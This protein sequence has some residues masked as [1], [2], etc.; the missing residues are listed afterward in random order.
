MC[1]K[2][3]VH[4]EF[5]SIRGFKHPRGVLKQTPPVDNGRLLYFL[6][7][8]HEKRKLFVIWFSLDFHA[9]FTS[10][11]LTHILVASAGQRQ[12]V[13]VALESTQFLSFLSSPWN[14]SFQDLA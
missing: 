6:K 9:L 4:T 12:A 1:K 5:N 11:F 7:V 8:K 2:K 3:P 10:L 13:D 14:L